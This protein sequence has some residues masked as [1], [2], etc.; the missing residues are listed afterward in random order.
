MPD[1]DPAF[2]ELA[3][4]V[5]PRGRVVVCASDPTGMAKVPTNS[6]GWGSEERRC[7]QYQ[8][9]QLHGSDPANTAGGR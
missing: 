5:R 4:V 7:R 2:S 8:A 1:L 6:T 3:R 9:R